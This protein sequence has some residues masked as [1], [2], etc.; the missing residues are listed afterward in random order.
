MND[1]YGFTVTYSDGHT[2]TFKYDSY[3]KADDERTIMCLK[4][5]QDDTIDKITFV[6]KL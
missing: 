2:Y 6:T 3:R 5:I 1:M 4:A